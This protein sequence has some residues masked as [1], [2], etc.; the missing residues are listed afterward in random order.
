L[1]P[2]DTAVLPIH[3]WEKKFKT[4]SRFHAPFLFLLFCFLVANSQ[5]WNNL[6]TTKSCQI[7]S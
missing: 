3:K 7:L 6:Q 2:T 1:E 5:I 4:S